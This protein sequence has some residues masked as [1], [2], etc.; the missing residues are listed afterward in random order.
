MLFSCWITEHVKEFHKDV[1]LT[2]RIS[3]TNLPK[4][5]EFPA[6]IKSM[7]IQ[8]HYYQYHLTQFKAR[9]T[10]LALQNFCILCIVHSLHSLRSIL[11]AK[12]WCR[13]WIRIMF[14]KS[15]CKPFNLERVTMRTIFF[16]KPTVKNLYHNEIIISRSNYL[17]KIGR[18]VIDA[19]DCL[20]LWLHYI[21]YWSWQYVQPFMCD[22]NGKR[23]DFS[24]SLIVET[25][26]VWVMGWVL[27]YT[28][29]ILSRNTVHKN[30]MNASPYSL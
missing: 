18:G 17:E 30:K 29:I 23:L 27:N 26:M 3:S 22:R 4:L 7:L 6:K 20:L 19:H 2:G 28:A 25:N 5:S 9:K 24:N 21:Q 12:R 16:Q 1:H 14:N 11:H 10:F 8:P 15:C 13:A